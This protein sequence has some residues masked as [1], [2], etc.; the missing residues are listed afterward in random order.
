[1]DE[2]SREDFMKATF[3]L[4]LFATFT[5]GQV[6]LTAEEE[7]IIKEAHE[8]RKKAK[9]PPT[10]HMQDKMQSGFSEVKT[11]KGKCRFDL[12]GPETLP[13]GVIKPD[14]LTVN[15]CVDSAIELLEKNKDHFDKAIVKHSLLKEMKV[16]TLKKT[17][18]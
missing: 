3:L 10:Q 1:M 11:D 13:E 5:W 7:Q 6:K 12:I 17:K 16:V 15:E 9:H 14:P 4:L 18:K 8:F 2:Y